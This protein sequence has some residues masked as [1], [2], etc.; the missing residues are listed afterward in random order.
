MV[1]INQRAKNRVFA[2]NDRGLRIG[3]DHPRAVLLDAEVALLLEL[4]EQGL[5]L[6]TLAKK[7]DIHKG[8]AAKICSGARRGQ[9]PAAW[10]GAR[11][12]SR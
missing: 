5:S 12:P 4:R 1:G 2:V 3:E 8:T 7:F 11:S 9:S 10:R 6:G